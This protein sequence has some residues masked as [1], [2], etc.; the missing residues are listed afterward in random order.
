[1]KIWNRSADE[2]AKAAADISKAMLAA[3]DRSQAVIEFSLDGTILAANENFCAT[4]GYTIDEIRGKHHSMFVEPGLRSVAGVQD[5]LGRPRGPASS[6]R[7]STSA[8]AK[9]GKEVWIQATYNPLVGDDGKAFRVV[10]FASDVT[11][12]EN[13]RKAAEIERAERAEQA[14]VVFSIGGGLEGGRGWQPH[15]P[16]EQD[17]PGRTTEV[18][19][20]DFNEA[21]TKLQD[22]MT[23]IAGTAGGI[24]TGSA[25]ISQAADD[26]SRR[27]EQQ[28]ASLEQTAAALDQITA[29]V[30]KSAEGASP[31][32]QGRR[33]GSQGW[34][35][36]RRGREPARAAAMDKIEKLRPADQ[37][38]HRR[39]RRDRVPDQLAGAQ[40]RRRGRKSRRCRPRLCRRGI[41]SARTGPALG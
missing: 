22:A 2:H 15:R 19:R 31:G 40:C 13:E 34:P 18:L 4:V 24:H 21:M 39:D 38:D 17:V 23:T 7:P 32:Q 16:P 14:K 11:Q 29:T 1:M 36:N 20:N 35:S 33:H 30:K 28:A 41:G 37:P 8:S 27:T 9:G 12:V 10:K 3:L 5:F 26:L 6:R 25:E